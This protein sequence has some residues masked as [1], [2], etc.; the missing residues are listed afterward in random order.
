MLC[1]FPDGKLLGGMIG[2]VILVILAVFLFSLVQLFIFFVTFRQALKSTSQF[3]EMENWL[4]R[5][6]C[7][8]KELDMPLET[9]FHIES[10]LNDQPVVD[11]LSDSDL[12]IWLAAQRAVPRYEGLLSSVLGPRGRLLRKLLI[13]TGF[14][15]SMQETSFDIDS[16]SK[17]SEPY[18]RSVQVKLPISF[19]KV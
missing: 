7:W 3:Q 10:S 8:L 2:H 9:R 14:I 4:E 1:N 15:P 6:R 17:V 12:P 11:Q 13:W 18:L 5:A 19:L 16:A